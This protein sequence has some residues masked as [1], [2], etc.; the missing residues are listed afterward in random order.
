MKLSYFQIPPQAACIMN[1]S[2]ESQHLSSLIVLYLFAYTDKRK[3]EAAEMR[4]L[5]PTAGCTLLE[6][7]EV[8]T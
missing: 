7:K 1:I 8:A 6:E 4:F 3:I 5:R 2:G